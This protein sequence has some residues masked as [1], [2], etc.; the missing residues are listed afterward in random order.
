MPGIFGC[1]DRSGDRVPR[2]IAVDMVNS[3]KHEDFYVDEWILDPCLLGAVEL[4]SLHNKNNLAYDDAKSLIGVSRGNIYN[5]QEL[6]RKLGIQSTPYYSNDAKFIVELYEKEGLDFAKHLNGLFLAAIYDKEKDR[7][8]IANDRC[9]YYPLFYSL[10]CKR[11]IFAS[12]AKALLKDPITS[13]VINESAIPEFF[14]F[15]FLLGDKTF[16][17]DI[18]WMLP[19]RILI[20]D[21]T[22]DKIDLKRYWD[23]SV[24]PKQNRPG[25]SLEFALKVFRKLMK[26]AVERRVSDRKEVG[27]FL[28]SGLDS[29]LVAAFASET[30]T[31]VTT[32]TFGAKNCPDQKIAKQVAEKL[33]L[34]NVFFEIP[35]DFIGNYA[36][37]IVYKG[38]GMIRIRDCH[39]IALLKKISR[40]VNTVLL[41]TDLSVHFSL[42]RELNKVIGLRKKKEIIAYLFQIYQQVLREEEHQRAFSESFFDMIKGEAKKNFVKSF[43]EIVLTSPEDIWDYWEYRNRQPRYVFN[44][45]QYI[46]WYLETRHPF[47]DKD[48][49]DFLTF[50]FPHDFGWKNPF[51][52]K[53]IKYCFPSLASIPSHF[54]VPPDSRQ[55][56][57]FMARARGFVY[58]KIKETIEKLSHGAVT[59]SP[60]DYREYGGWLRT[61]SK[62]Y[63]LDIL[64]D[65]RTLKRGFFKPDYVKRI[66]EEHMNYKKDN[67][68]LICDLINFELMNRIFFDVKKEK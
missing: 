4:E 55:S 66:L 63:V 25:V 22:T 33:G 7:I 52:R 57:V 21:R 37:D 62:E 14:T 5:K 18:K 1:I 51:L 11:F 38:D 12:E 35:S 45:F 29:R 68:Q 59:L 15:S 24:K 20:Y 48:L 2:K 41:G 13:P 56:V 6:S 10:N 40:K 27:V 49:I 36:E 3:L 17:R 9:G 53:A 67:N 32:F 50:N 28:S 42:E 30:D 44:L 23:F 39:F 54:G 46:N 61:G 8:I 34:E 60:V 43:D 31:S 58:N 19:A 26:K 16:F 65:S 64:L 47:L